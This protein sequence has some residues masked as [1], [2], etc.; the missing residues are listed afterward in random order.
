MNFEEIVPMQTAMLEIYSASEGVIYG[1][2]ESNYFVRI[3]EEW[4]SLANGWTGMV[5]G[6]RGGSLSNG[7]ICQIKSRE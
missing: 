6:T 7:L 2:V 5:G 4:T 3:V 1:I